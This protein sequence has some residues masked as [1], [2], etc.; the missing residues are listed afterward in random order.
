MVRDATRAQAVGGVQDVFV[1]DLADQAQVRMVAQQILDE[2]GVVDVLFNNAGVLLD[3]IYQSPQDNE[4]PLLLRPGGQTCW[5]FGYAYPREERF[6][7]GRGQGYWPG[8]RRG[9]RT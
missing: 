6:D 9:V 3:G 2:W 7:H 8:D 1:A 5:E 4:M